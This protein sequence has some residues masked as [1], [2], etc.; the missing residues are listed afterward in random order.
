MG[1]LHFVRSPYAHAHITLDR[2][3]EGGGDQGRATGRSRGEEVAS[4]TDPFFQL[5]TPPGGR[6]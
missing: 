1:Y 2:R 6:I 4:L 3:L 5:A